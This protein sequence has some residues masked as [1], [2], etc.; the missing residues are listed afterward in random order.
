MSTA[1]SNKKTG[2]RETGTQRE[3]P[4]LIGGA[5]RDGELVRARLS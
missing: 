1:I 4:L 5:A 2:I 3:F